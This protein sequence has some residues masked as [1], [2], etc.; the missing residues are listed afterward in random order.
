[1]SSFSSIE[2]K[3]LS[4]PVCKRDLSIFP[5]DIVACPYCGVSL[6]EVK[7]IAL[8]KGWK[9]LTYSG[10][11]VLTFAI[12]ML[13][14]ILPIALFLLPV[15]L[16]LLVLGARRY[17]AYKK[18][19]LFEKTLPAEPPK[20]PVPTWMVWLRRIL[21]MGLVAWIVSV[22]VHYGPAA[23]IL[24]APHIILSIV[25]A[26][27]AFSRRRSTI[28]SILILLLSVGVF[29][30]I[31]FPP[32]FL[33]LGPPPLDIPGLIGDWVAGRDPY[34]VDS[35]FLVVRSGLMFSTGLAVFATFL[36]RLER[37]R[38]FE[39]KR[40][41]K[42]VTVAIVLLPIA[43]MCLVPIGEGVA[44][45]SVT[46]PWGYGGNGGWQLDSDW[47][48]TRV[49]NSKTHLWVYSIRLYNRISKN[50]TI[51][52]IWAWHEAIEP[53][54]TRVTF[55]GTGIFVSAQGILFEPGASGVIT[56]ATEQGHNKVTLLL[57]NNS[58]KTFS[59]GNPSFAL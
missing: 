34:A 5:S 55:N 9:R 29:A 13:F 4:C 50:I 36:L 51:L 22:F 27:Y 48:T 8:H 32:L 1:M 45:P 12:L 19:R 26:A 56:F 17:K 7:P 21:A 10:L 42:I 53:L 3:V 16:I 40:I 46:R 20:I 47:N 14:L 28:G 35:I 44:N 37:L 15:A 41:T 11:I 31:V 38:K 23:L 33:F 39:V 6:K 24:F 25:V 18:R 52:K 58:I 2:S 54:S 57:T 30:S 49:Y 43:V 59:W